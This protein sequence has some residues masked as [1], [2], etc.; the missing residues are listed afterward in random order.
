MKDVFTYEK[1]KHFSLTIIYILS[2][3]V[4]IFFNEVQFCIYFQVKVIASQ[5]VVDG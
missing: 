3:C 2:K 5:E 1:I 4:S